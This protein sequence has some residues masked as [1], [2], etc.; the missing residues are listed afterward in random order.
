MNKDISKEFAASYDDYILQNGWYSPDILFGLCYQYISKN[1]RLLDIGIGTGLSSAPFKKAGL[2]IYGIDNSEHMLAICRKK[3]IVEELR[4]HD[5]S[6]LPLPFSD[7]FFDIVIANGIFH[8]TGPLHSVFSESSRLLKNNGIF[9]FTIDMLE[10]IDRK[11]Y[12]ESDIAGLWSSYN[13]DHDFYLYKHSQTHITDLLKK[14]RFQQLKSVHFRAFHDNK[15]NR[16]IYFN[17]FITG[18]MPEV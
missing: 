4:E 17:A 13:K 10:E 14:Y 6:T 3:N 2:K 12:R 7:Q 16:T 9:A 1:Q 5:L 18:K 15:E 8:L 11:T